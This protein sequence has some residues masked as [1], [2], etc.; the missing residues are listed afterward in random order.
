ML[1]VVS[2]KRESVTSANAQALRCAGVNSTK[3]LEVALADVIP[4]VWTIKPT[5]ECAG[6]A[7]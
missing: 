6:K 3:E 4:Q 1:G 5:V 7:P 2:L